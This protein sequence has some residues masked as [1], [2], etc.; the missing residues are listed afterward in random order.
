MTDAS[1]MEEVIRT[2]RQLILA[3]LND[4]AAEY[5]MGGVPARAMKADEVLAIAARNHARAIDALPLQRQPK[6]WHEP[7]AGAA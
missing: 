2:R 4:A 7:A 1:P 6:G 3:A 5:G